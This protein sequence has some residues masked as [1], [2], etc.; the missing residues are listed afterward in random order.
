M[1]QIEVI[2]SGCGVTQIRR[3]EECGGD[4][5]VP[6]LSFELRALRAARRLPLD[7]V[8]QHDKRFLNAYAKLQSHECYVDK[9][10]RQLKKPR[11]G[12]SLQRQSILYVYTRRMRH[13]PFTISANERRLAL[14]LLVVV[15]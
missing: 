5:V 8:T 1:R 11:C 10:V 3:Y 14:H 15:D 13:G 2:D 7:D 4:P 12:A 9:A 6:L